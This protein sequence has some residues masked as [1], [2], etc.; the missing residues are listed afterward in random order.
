MSAELPSTTEPETVLLPCPEC[1]QMTGSLKSRRILTIIFVVFAYGAQTKPTVA[2]PRCMR[3]NLFASGLVNIISAN[4]LW[5]I[6]ILPMTLIQFITTYQQG[7]SQEILDRLKPKE[8]AATVQP[9]AAEPWKPGPGF[10]RFVGVVKVLVGAGIAAYV[11]FYV[12]DYWY[13]PR[14]E[15]WYKFP[16][17]LGVG[18]AGAIVWSGVANLRLASARWKT[19]GIV[20]VA[21]AVVIF[22]AAPVLARVYWQSKAERLA[23]EGDL[24]SYHLDVPAEMWQA[25]MVNRIVDWKS[26]ALTDQAARDARWEAESS[27]RDLWYLLEDVQAHHAGNEQFRSIVARLEALLAEYEQYNAWVRDSLSPS[28]DAADF[29]VKGD[30]KAQ[31]EAP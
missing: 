25:D 24:Y 21:M 31:E 29:S 22:V 26:E 5:P 19:M 1:K 11:A 16:A 30:P 4:V 20:A 27:Y 8:P 18:V 17:A 10:K 7:H 3:K 14:M 2:C 9:A 12:L 6:I 23:R 28:P 15:T 13:D